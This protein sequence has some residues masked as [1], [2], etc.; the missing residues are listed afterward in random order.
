M[1]VLTAP[2]IS[3]IRLWTGDSCDYISDVVMQRWLQEVAPYSV[4]RDQAIARVVVR[5]LRAA[6]AK[7][8]I[9]STTAFGGVRSTNAESIRLRA[10]LDDWLRLA[11]WKGGRITAGVMEMNLSGDDLEEWEA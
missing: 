11:G 5:M 3:D 7:A 1:D 2:E 10:I 8:K 4:D 6:I 9:Q